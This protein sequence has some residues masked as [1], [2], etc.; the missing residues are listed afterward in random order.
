MADTGQRRG[1][2]WPSAG[3]GRP[4][5]GTDPDVGPE[6][7][8]G[9][10]E[11]QVPEAEAPAHGGLSHTFRGGVAGAQGGLAVLSGTWGW[12]EGGC[13][14]LLRSRGPGQRG[15]GGLASCDGPAAER[16]PGPRSSEGLFRPR[17]RR[18]AGERVALHPPPCGR[19]LTTYVT[20]QRWH[21]GHRPHTGLSLQVPPHWSSLRLP[22][23]RRRPRRS[24]PAGQGAQVPGRGVWVWPGAHR[25][26]CLWA[27]SPLTPGIWEGDCGTDARGPPPPLPAQHEMRP[28]HRSPGAARSSGAQGTGARAP[29]SP[30]LMMAAAAVISLARSLTPW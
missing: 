2:G 3:P 15:R 26:P 4:T 10:Q 7:W 5:G 6:A 20:S 29:G 16:G 1:G 17:G 24:R 21:L 11:E 9:S 13:A 27:P 12:G 30:P 8:G 22:R 19:A 14:F 28:P 18:P 23:L 25:P